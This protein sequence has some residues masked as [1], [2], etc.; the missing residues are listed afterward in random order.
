MKHTSLAFILCVAVVLGACTQFSN[1]GTH[2]LPYIGSSNTTTLSIESVTLTD[3]STVLGAVVHYRP[4]WWFDI[5]GNSCIVADGEKYGMTAIDGIAADKRVTTPDSGVVRF[6]MTFPAIPPTVKAIDFTENVD[7]GFELREI[8]LT[9]QASPADFAAQ[10]PTKVRNTKT[11]DHL[12]QTKIAYDTTIVNLHIIGYR[13][14]MKDVNYILD[15]AAGYYVNDKSAT[16]DSAGNVQLIVDL[17][18][19]AN[20]TIRGSEQNNLIGSIH[21]A[22]GENIDVFIDARVSGLLNMAKRDNID[23]SYPAG[24][25]PVYHNGIYAAIDNLQWQGYPDYAMDVNGG[26]FAD[27]HMSG[28]EYTAYTINTYKALVDSVDASD[29]PQILKEYRKAQLQSELAFAGAQ[30]ENLLEYQYRLRNDF[31]RRPIPADSLPT[32]SQQNIR[33]IAALVD[34]NNP[35]IYIGNYAVET[36][37][38]KLWRRNGID[39]GL[40]DGIRAYASCMEPLY[41]G[42]PLAE[43]PADLDRAPAAFAQHIAARKKYVEQ[44]LAS[45]DWSGVTPTP[46]V[47]PDKLIE[48]ITAPHKGKVVM[49]DL[50]NT[51]CTPCRNAIKTNEPYKNA[52]LSSDDIVWIYIADE[53]SPAPTYLDMIGNIRGIHYRLTNDQ[54]QAVRSRFGVDGI[55]YYI[56]VDRSGKATG[57]PD[58]RDHDKFRRTLKESL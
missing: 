9:G 27:Y 48:A 21:I 6:T 25:Q 44:K 56:L 5:D 31:W 37:D 43:M 11:A 58:L 42:Q 47:T 32:L 14:G 57:R 45:L 24:Y 8:D 53:S 34:F 13:P 51:W 22:P 19:P 36:S 2:E 38:S 49:I 29:M 16:P 17:A 39:A 7:D 41:E 30:Y 18:A 1:R 26:N 3:S 40:Y 54:I 4:G 46:D 52:E 28:D 23:N 12:P 50:W 33:D 20:M 15:S 35:L 10:V 55:P